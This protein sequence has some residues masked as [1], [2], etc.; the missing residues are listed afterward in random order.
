MTGLLLALHRV[1]SL[2]A[3]A[4]QRVRLYAAALLGYV[5]FALI[6]VFA[7]PANPDPVPVPIDLLELFRTLTMIGQFLLWAFLAA[8]VALALMWYQRPA[9][10][11]KGARE[12]VSQKIC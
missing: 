10:A 7:T 2:V 3:L 8:G 4:E 1:S 11:G 9:R 12:S 5:A 6:I